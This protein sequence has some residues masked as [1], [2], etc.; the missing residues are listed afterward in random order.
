M[1][2]QKQI[3]VGAVAYHPR[4]VTIWERFRD[5]FADAGVPTDY[6]LYSN[7][8][9]LVD[10][11]LHGEV[12]IAWNTNTA[13]VAAEQRIGGDAQ[14][15]GMRDVDAEFRTVIAVRRGETFDELAELEGQRLA[16]G[17]RD[18]GHAAILPLHWVHEAGVRPELVR[19]DTDL[20]KHGDTGDSELR[21]VEAV[22]RGGADAGALGDA[23]WVA[24]RSEGHP[25]VSG[26][27]LAWRSP[28]Y[29]H[30]NFTA[31]PAF[32]GAAWS[33][34]LLAMSYADPT[35]R[36]AMDLE[37][38]KRWLQPDKAGYETLTHAMQEQGYLG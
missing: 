22:S 15:L 6:V 36:P 35:L 28:V 4:I 37:G 27:E 34:A 30:C 19:F 14:L 8:E 9:R 2:D 25:A 18:S 17:S 1:S 24:L 16:L 11:L 10:A 5:Y 12:D 20:G 23:T 26:L 13:Y 21:V 32:D 29:Y 7:Y 38:V 33:D 3:L 31:L